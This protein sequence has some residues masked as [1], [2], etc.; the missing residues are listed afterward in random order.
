MGKHNTWV[1]SVDPAEAWSEGLGQFARVRTIVGSIVSEGGLTVL[2]FMKAHPAYG[3]S[4]IVLTIATAIGL[5]AYRKFL[6]SAVASGA[7]LH[8]ICHYI[9]DESGL[10]LQSTSPAELAQYRERYRQFHGRVAETIASYFRAIA[11]DPKICCAIRLADTGGGK[12]EYITAGRSTGMDPNRSSMSEPV[13]HDEGI[14]ELLRKKGQMGVC[15][16]HDI[17]EAAERNWW[18][19]C[20]SDKLKDVKTLIIAPINGFIGGTKSM[21]GMLYVTSPNDSFRL[22]H[23]EPMKAFADLLGAVYPLITGRMVEQS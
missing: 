20:K 7:R 5:I 12:Q 1:P 3:Y 10:I 11:N 9:R 21:V 17:K 23:A 19:E 13:K 15:F 22:T 14:A 4:G 18:K 2:L 6:F 8:E 16:I